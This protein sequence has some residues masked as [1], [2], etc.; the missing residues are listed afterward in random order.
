MDDKARLG[1]EWLSLHDHSEQY[2]KHALLI[3]LTCLALCVGGLAAKLPVGW[4]GALVV[5]C[6]MQ[7]GILKTG[8][9]R[10]V[11]RLLR[12]EAVLRQAAPPDALA[13]QLYSA[14]SAAR[15]GWIGLLR[16]YAVNAARPTVAFPY[17]PILLLGLLTS[18]ITA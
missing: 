5:L 11:E 13:M 3:K 9:V 7:E 10:L 14:W 6:W 15:P 17:L 4:L 12:L 18:L 8:Q 2:E 1:Q 16:E